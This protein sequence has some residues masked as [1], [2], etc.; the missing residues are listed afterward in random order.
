MIAAIICVLVSAVAFTYLS[1]TDPKRRRTF[2][3]PAWERQRW[4]RLAWVLAFAP[5]FLLLV[6]GTGAGFVVWLGGVMVV[7]WG[8]AAIDP[9]RTQALLDGFRG[10]VGGQA[11][12]VS[13]PVGFLSALRARVRERRALGTR[14]QILE[15][16]VA[17]LEARFPRA[18]RAPTREHPLTR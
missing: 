11:K 9:S 18:R 15:R 14:V 12:L 17:E 13:R 8:V 4:S 7:G 3:L 2:R 1:A 16:R 5:G 6:V 10:L